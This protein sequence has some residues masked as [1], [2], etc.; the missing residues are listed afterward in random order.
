[1]NTQQLSS[2]NEIVSIFFLISNVIEN[3][4]YEYIFSKEFYFLLSH[5]N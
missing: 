3:V 1:M 5:V 2:F 4:Q